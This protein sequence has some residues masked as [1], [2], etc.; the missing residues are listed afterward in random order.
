MSA[1]YV[2]MKPLL[3]RVPTVDDRSLRIEQDS[4]PHFYRH[5]HFHPEIQLTLIQQGEGTL[6]AGDKIDRF[7]KWFI[8][9]FLCWKR[10]Q[11][12]RK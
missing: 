11:A 2:L 12:V 1:K 8:V 6:I 4:A 9:S 10:T 5:L 7:G 3:F